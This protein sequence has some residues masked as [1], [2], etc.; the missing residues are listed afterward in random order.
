M[1]DYDPTTGRYIESDPIGLRGGINTYT[2]V[3]NKPL[4][5]TDRRGLVFG[6]DDA[7]E[8][9]FA[10]S[11]ELGTFL[12]SGIS[13]AL[14][15]SIGAGI[16]NATHHSDFCPYQNNNPYRGKPG[17]EST[18]TYPDG[19]PK[20]TRRYGPDGYPQTDTD[21]HPDHGAGTPH[22][23]DWS[24]P[25]SRGPGRAPQPGDPGFPKAGGGDGDGDG[26]G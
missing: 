13:A 7:A 12:N 25:T 22:T 9:D 4:D 15:I 20:Q 18:S 11:F 16:Y 17:S 26:G 19:T 1:R 8:A 3:G 10:V 21:Y 5:Y 2:Y 6:V 24:S 23:H 14:G